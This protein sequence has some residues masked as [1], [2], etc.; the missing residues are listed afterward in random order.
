VDEEKEL[1]PFKHIPDLPPFLL[2]APHNNK[3]NTDVLLPVQ[4]GE[5][6]EHS[7]DTMRDFLDAVSTTAT[8]ASS[9]AGSL[10]S[11]TAASSL[12]GD[13]RL[14]SPEPPTLSSVSEHGQEAASEDAQ[15]AASKDAQEAASEDGK[16][17]ALVEAMGESA[18]ENP[19]G[20]Q[21]LLEELAEKQEDPKKETDYEEHSSSEEE[22]EEGEESPTSLDFSWTVVPPPASRLSVQ[23]I[24][25][26]EFARP[27]VEGGKGESE[28]LGE[29]E[30]A[31]R[32]SFAQPLDV[33]MEE[34]KDG[35]EIDEQAKECRAEEPA[36]ELFR[37]G[38][39]QVGGHSEELIEAEVNFQFSQPLYVSMQEMMEVEESPQQQQE[40]G[41]KVDD[42]LE[43][44]LAESPAKNPSERSVLAETRSNKTVRKDRSIETGNQEIRIETAKESS[45]ILP[46]EEP[47]PGAENTTLAQEVSPPAEDVV[48]DKEVGLTQAK[49]PPVMVVCQPPTEPED[50]LPA[51]LVERASEEEPQ[52]QV[53]HTEEEVLA[54]DRQGAEESS[55]VESL[56]TPAGGRGT[57]SRKLATPS[58]SAKP[59]RGGATKAKDSVPSTEPSQIVTTVPPESDLPEKGS[60]EESRRRSRTPPKSSL[61]AAGMA[62]AP[63]STPPK[64][65]PRGRRGTVAAQSVDMAVSIPVLDDKEATPLRRSSRKQ[66]SAPST[67]STLTAVSS[68]T[69]LSEETTLGDKLTVV[70]ERGS[71]ME[72]VETALVTPA[73]GRPSTSR[74]RRSDTPVVK[75]AVVSAVARRGRITTTPG[76]SSSAEALV[77]ARFDKSLASSHSLTAEEE[78][79][80]EKTPEA[81]KKKKSNVGSCGSADVGSRRSRNTSNT[82]VK[83]PAESVEI[84]PTSIRKE[85]NKTEET[86]NAGESVTLGARRTRNTSGPVKA[87]A[88]PVEV[89]L[90]SARKGRNN[91]SSI[92]EAAEATTSPSVARKGKAKLSPEE[93]VASPVTPAVRKGRKT[94]RLVDAEGTP[95]EENTE[96]SMLTE[97]VVPASD[98]M[99]ESPVAQATPQV[100]R[101]L[102]RYTGDIVVFR[103]RYE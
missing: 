38:P 89:V 80:E 93:A 21:Q 54:K 96:S 70:P 28:S 39:L 78:G 31:V 45:S 20:S 22:E 2:P 100:G 84:P 23:Q 33:S 27:L 90:P 98:E 8:R 74:A 3:D 34:E 73:R 48:A 87:C 12:Y 4:E 94:R 5:E 47:S 10:F 71:K 68:L 103:R 58:S 41:E 62:H 56:A 35:D 51:M 75:S 24:A 88:T 14:T 102:V 85:R 17:A 67:P 25:E 52:V 72:G 66:S 64:Q 32:F 53:S 69:V 42:L 77:I 49:E 30:S 1:G 60:E 95:V 40:T 83:P 76:P 19:R 50:A 43:L 13:S 97:P 61:E 86:V 26:M 37:F 99:V 15:E 9:V 92:V 18:D 63:P 16:E 101:P 36:G 65:S 11:E 81:S 46:S 29:E 7:G 59:R 6:E 91:S 82:P 55:A 57:R 44:R 79:P